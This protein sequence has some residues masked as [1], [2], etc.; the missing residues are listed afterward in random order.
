MTLSQLGGQYDT[1]DWDIPGT[2]TWALRSID[3]TPFSGEQVYVRFLYVGGQGLQTKFGID[4]F[5][6]SG[7]PYSLSTVTPS[8]AAVGARLTLTGSGFGATQGSGVVRF[9][10]GAGG[11]VTQASMLRWEAGLIEC[12]VPAGA[13][14]HSAAGVWVVANGLA[15]N[16]RPL[17]V[18]LPAP[19]LGGV[20]Q[21]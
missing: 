16:G 4:E 1:G 18:V 7:E 13:K 6:L 11:W 15:S 9:S 21:R 10:D 2:G 12:F 3:L 19:G 8:R 14:S 20:E 5:S 17:T